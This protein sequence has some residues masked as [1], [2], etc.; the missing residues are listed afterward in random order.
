MGEMSSDTNTQIHADTNTEIDVH[1]HKYMHNTQ[2][3]R[4]M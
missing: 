3:L 2:T 4:Y 1:K